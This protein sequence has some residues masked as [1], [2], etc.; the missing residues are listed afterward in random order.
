MVSPRSPLTALI[1]PSLAVQWALWQWHGPT[2]QTSLCQRRV[3]SWGGPSLRVRAR[4][5]ASARHSCDSI[6]TITIATG[7]ASIPLRRPPHLSPRYP[8]RAATWTPPSPSPTPTIVTCDAVDAATTKVT[9]N[10]ATTFFFAN[11]RAARPATSR[12]AY[13][14]SPSGERHQ[15][16]GQPPHRR[17]R[18]STHHNVSGRSLTA[19]DRRRGLQ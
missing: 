12:A 4:Q 13:W 16:V 17:S 1:Y 11:E 8:S 5:S 10:A 14:S 2:S 3:M 18:V 6:R 19:A 9:T 7:I 15:P